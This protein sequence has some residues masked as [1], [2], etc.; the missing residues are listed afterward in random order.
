M[1]LPLIAIGPA[2]K[3]V[4]AFLKGVPREIWLLLAFLALVGAAVLYQAHRERMAFRAGEAARQALWDASIERGKQEIARLDAENAAKDEAAR[5]AAQHIGENR[6]RDQQDAI[7]AKD[8]L[9]DGLRTGNQ[10]LRGQFQACLSDSQ[11]SASTAVPSG[12]VQPDSVRPADAL[13]LAGAVGN[14]VFL[15]DDAD[16]RHARLVEYVDTL[17]SACGAAP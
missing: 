15:A 16:S 11:A 7:T 2:L 3:A 10:R 14:S 9:I 4:G 8:R 6:V 5:I 13:D 17:R 12:P 1:A